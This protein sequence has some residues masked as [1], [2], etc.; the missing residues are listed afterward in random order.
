MIGDNTACCDDVCP[1]IRMSHSCTLKSLNRI[2]C[3]LAG[4]DTHV[5]P[6]NT[7]LD[8][9]LGPTTE[10]GDL[11]PVAKR[12]LL[13]DRG[14]KKIVMLPFAHYKIPIIRKKDCGCNGTTQY[15]KRALFFFAHNF[16]KSQP[17]FTILA[18]LHY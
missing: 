9:D 17:I 16:D 13:T 11:R 3:H 5:V 18:N 4:K 10:R 1:S 15:L 12:N 8:R 2:R 6:S 7:V 14:M